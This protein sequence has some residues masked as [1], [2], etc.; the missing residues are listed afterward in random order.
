MQKRSCEKRARAVV[1]V[2][3]AALAALAFVL[4]AV[5]TCATG[6]VSTTT[7]QG[8]IYRADGTAASGTVLISW[9]AFI[10]AQNQAVAA[11]SLSAAIGANGFLSVN[12]MPNA[13]ALPAG[14]YYTAVY[15]LSDGTVNQEYWV[16]PAAGTASV[17]SVRAQLQ[18]S[19]VAVQPAVTEAYVQSAISS[20]GGGYLPL[21]GGTLSGP[22]TLSGDPVSGNQAATK[23]YADSLSG[24][25]LPMGGGSLTGPVSAPQM[26]GVY[27][28]DGVVYA[29]V[30]SAIRACL[31]QTPAPSACVID[32]HGSGRLGAAADVIWSGPG[33][34]D[35]GTTALTLELGPYLDYTVGSSIVLES[36]MNLIGAGGEKGAQGGT[37]ITST[38]TSNAPILILPI[39]NG[40]MG[41]HA[42]HVQLRGVGF[43][44][45]ASNT[46]QEGMDLDC[47]A[48]VGAGMA[49]SLFEDLRFTGFMGDAIHLACSPNYGQS[50]I[51]DDTFIDVTAD[52][53]AG[54]GYALYLG[55]SVGNLD[56]LNGNFQ[57]EGSATCDTTGP[58]NGTDVY[59]GAANTPATLAASGYSVAAVNGQN[60]ASVTYTSTMP[61]SPGV[62]VNLSGFTNSAWAPYING[63]QSALGGSAP[64]ILQ[65]NTSAPATAFVADPGA[66]SFSSRYNGT[67]TFTSYSVSGGVATVN[68]SAATVP[69][70][71]G[72]PVLLSGFSTSAANGFFNNQTVSILSVTGQAGSGPSYSGTITFSTAAPNTASTPDSGTGFESANFD[73]YSIRFYGTTIENGGTLVDLNGANNISFIATHHEGCSGTTNGFLFTQGGSQNQAITV[74]GALFAANIGT[75]ANGYLFNTQNSGTALTLNVENTDWGTPTT[76]V[77][78]RTGNASQILKLSNNFG[79]G[80]GSSGVVAVIPAASTLNLSPSGAGFGF[81]EVSGAAQICSFSASTMPGESVTLRATGSPGN[82]FGTTAAGCASSNLNLNGLP[83]LWLGSGETA[84]FIPND[85]SGTWDLVSLGKSANRELIGLTTLSDTGLAT[86]NQ[87][88]NI[89]S[90]TY[91]NCWVSRAYAGSGLWSPSMSCTNGSPAKLSFY[92]SPRAAKGSETWS[93]L[94][95]AQNGLF[96]VPGNLGVGSAAEVQGAFTGASINGEITVDG[97]T[98]P[99]LNAAWNAAVSVANASGKNQTIR[100][101]PGTFPVTA[102]LGEPG[103]GACVSVIGSAGTTMNADSAQTATTLTA[104]SSLAGDVFFLGN[105][106]QAQGCTFKDLNLLAGGNAT[107]GFEL[108]WFRGL[109]LDNVTVN[110]TTAEG[111]L[112]GEETSAHQASFLLRNVTVSYSSAAFTPANRPAYGIHLQQTAM[113]SHLDAIVVRNALTAAVWNEG[114]GNTGYLIHGFGYPYTC[115]TAPCANN[116][117]TG[118]AANASYATNYVIY[119]T[120]GGGS[121]WTDTYA[122]SPA[123]AGFYVGANGVEIH[124]GH[125]QWP[126]L[127]SFPS[128]NL[129]YVAANVSNNLLIAD[130][131]CLEMASGVNWITYAGTAGNPPTFASVH[132]LTGC[133][134]YYQALEPAVTTGFSSGGANINDPSGAVP[135]VWAT[136][137]AAAPNEAAYAAQMYTGY[138]GD[139]FQAHFSGVA[140]FFNVTYQGT[141][142]TSGGIALGTVVNT[143]S[144]LALT[145]A[146]KNVIANAASGPQTITLPSCFTP[147][148]DNTPPTGLEFTIVKSDASSN[149]VT[150]ATT[151]SQLIYSQGVGAATLALASPSTQT[152]VCGPD[153]NWYVAGSTAPAAAPSGVTSF[154]GRTGAVTPGASDYSF[155]QLTGQATNAQLPGTLTAPTTGNA[156]TATALAA[157]PTQCATGYY[158]T[159]VTAGGAANCLQSWHFTWYGNFAGTFGTTT[160]TSMGAIWSPTAAIKMTRLDIAVGTAPAGCTTYPV[161]G[162]YDSTSASW[163]KTVTLATGTFSYRNTASVAITAGHALSM[164]VQTAGAGCSTNPGTAQITM[165]YTMN[166]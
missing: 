137:L 100:L 92:G 15:H 58:A 115:P 66:G 25:G 131:D 164:G 54:G 50:A 125:I 37:L 114:T 89:V 32:A 7:V 148:A 105:A 128:A 163:L 153:N 76:V 160:N 104:P 33:N 109:L 130:M 42:W 38:S 154:N 103:N 1:C 16:V 88:Q 143:A 79:S 19:T 108:Q 35:P 82:N 77:T 159:G 135:R 156:A 102:T 5:P 57:G 36:G 97:T 95:S 117:A 85:A 83:S 113:D 3:W 49:Y 151:S 14:S 63:T 84:T 30:Q 145:A 60:V 110:D 136:P 65:F 161:I 67:A 96:S 28:V 31:G 132:H 140:P 21:T 74:D 116:A 158:A 119:D 149:A 10:T 165:E 39:Q 127:T 29:T 91:G 152:L 141:I 23:H 71:S 146:N 80:S 129:A 12:L 138:Q 69:L 144:T 6:Q 166:Q 52:R 26:S 101:G 107:H 59:I 162:I 94:A 45:A 147:L 157:A 56:F 40:H 73:A 8:T 93:L 64:G 111:I 55:G 123:I 122:D 139:A 11:G 126:D 70:E 47:T 4:A 87:F 120:G 24:L 78:G 75:G 112:L 22:L 51:D 150:L 90:S 99:N 41:S 27:M 61:I 9:R 134:N 121:V 155:A 17:A 106:A 34:L 142:R 133:G 13:G 18:P 72:T 68:Y 43:N 44:G 86:D 62:V 81:V 46:A 48:G 20:M 2:P 118:S 98:Y 124:G 53:Q